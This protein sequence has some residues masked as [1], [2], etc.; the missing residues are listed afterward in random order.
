MLKVDGID[1]VIYV[2][3]IHM[4]SFLWIDNALFYLLTIHINSVLVIII[5]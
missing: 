2:N 3:Y 4:V 1:I 5:K